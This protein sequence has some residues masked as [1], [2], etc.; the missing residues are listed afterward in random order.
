LF[1]SSASEVENLFTLEKIKSAYDYLCENSE[2][3]NKIKS[4]YFLTCL[5]N[6]DFWK[7]LQTI[8]NDS[9]KK[10]KRINKKTAIVFN[11]HMSTFGGGERSSLAYALALKNLGF[12]T[13]MVVTSPTPSANI[14]KF[15]G[16]DLSTVPVEFYPL[17][18]FNQLS[19]LNPDIFVN[20]SFGSF[21]KNQGKVGIYSVMFPFPMGFVENTNLNTYNL[22]LS[23]SSFTKKYTDYMWKI[24]DEKSCVLHPPIQDSYVRLA[25]DFLKNKVKKQ[26]SFITVGRFF[27]DNHC[28]NQHIMV[29]EFIK[30]R[31]EYK[32]LC[33]WDFHIVGNIND[34]SYYLKCVE[35][36]KNQPGIYFHKNISNTELSELL[37]KSCF[38]VHATGLNNQG[39]HQCEHFGLSIIEAM[40]HGC[41]PIV[42]GY[43]GVFDI[44]N[45]AKGMG[46]SYSSSIEL[47]NTMI[48]AVNL[49]ENKTK[50]SVSQELCLSSVDLVSQESFTKELNFLLLSLL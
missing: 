36:A 39:P 9:I 28:K 3:K 42:Y 14:S 38:Y 43:G 1:F 44:L 37:K 21:T 35:I 7:K 23:N 24:D 48:S 30:A 46:F 18:D 8:S 10:N 47:R 5:L 49:W 33:N 15:F 32:E 40:A 29:E 6:S 34:E 20:H 16:S 25:K 4:D 31:Y 17:K 41:V 50:L 12:D 11:V 45:V 26:K 27:P 13:K 22:F 19:K 2:I